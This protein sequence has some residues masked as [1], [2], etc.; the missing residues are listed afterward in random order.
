MGNARGAGVVSAGTNPASQNNGGLGSNE[1]GLERA[2]HGHA[3]DRN[4][5]VDHVCLLS[6]QWPGLVIGKLE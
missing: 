3:R 5:H 1:E 2:Q 6:F 4:P